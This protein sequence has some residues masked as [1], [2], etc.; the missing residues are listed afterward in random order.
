MNPDRATSIS[1]QSLLAD[2]LEVGGNVAEPV[3]DTDEL[4]AYAHAPPSVF[5]GR[6]YGDGMI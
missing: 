2:F 6:V 3:G 4:V 5:G 1:S